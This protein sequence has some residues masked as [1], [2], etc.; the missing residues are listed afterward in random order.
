M[1]ISKSIPIFINEQSL[2]MSGKIVETPYYST[3][4]FPPIQN[5]IGAIFITLFI[6]FVIIS[7]KRE[8]KKHGFKIKRNNKKEN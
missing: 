2:N 1:M 8:L 4:I 5:I 3:H 7:L 6:Y